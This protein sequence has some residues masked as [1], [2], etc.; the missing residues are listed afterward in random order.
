[1]RPFYNAANFYVY[2]T[3]RMIIFAVRVTDATTA[4]VPGSDQ[5]YLP[6]RYRDLGYYDNKPV[7]GFSKYNVR[8]LYD[9]FFDF[10]AQV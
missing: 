7:Q 3:F 6:A 5:N 9:K 2:K 10:R 8:I 4:I 1:M